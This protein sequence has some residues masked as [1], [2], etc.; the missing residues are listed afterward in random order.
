MG[1]V[2]RQFSLTERRACRLLVFWRSTQR[3]D[4]SSPREEKDLALKTRLREL[5]EQSPRSGYRRLYALLTREGR[6]ANHKRVYR[7]YWAE[8]LAVWE[9]VQKPQVSA[10]NQRWSID[11]MSDQLASDRRFRVLN[12]VSDFTREC[13]IMHVGTS[14]TGAD[15]ARLLTSVLAE[16]AQPT[17]L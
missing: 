12:V 7:I 2:C 13:L 3:H 11:F 8:C 16:R 4:R 1:F 9:R 6:I 10:A 14:I 5:A 17:R 15:V